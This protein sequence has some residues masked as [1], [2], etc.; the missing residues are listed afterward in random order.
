[1][2]DVSLIPWEAVVSH[3]LKTPLCALQAQ[4][5]RTAVDRSRILHDVQRM[6]RLIDQLHLAGLC[7]SGMVRMQQGSLDAAAATVCERLL[8]L[9]LDR[10]QRFVFRRIGGPVS[11]MMDRALAEEAICNLL[12]NAIKYAPSGSTIAVVVTSGGTVHVLDRGPGIPLSEVTQLFEPFRRGAGT[13]HLPGSGLGLSLAAS[14]MS[15]H[16]ASIDYRPR[17]GGGSCFR[18]KFKRPGQSSLGGTVVTLQHGQAVATFR[19]HGK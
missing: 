13:S 6:L 7:R 1:M 12:E 8:P 2:F 19:R 17:R 14:I 11:A 4:L 15:V 16:R 9:A 10:G 3:Q 18:L 5:Q